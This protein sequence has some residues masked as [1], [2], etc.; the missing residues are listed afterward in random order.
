MNIRAS[1][2]TLLVTAELLPEPVPADLVNNAVRALQRADNALGNL[3]AYVDARRDLVCRQASSSRRPDS[4]TRK[5]E[6]STTSDTGY[7]TTPTNKPSPSHTRSRDEPED[8]PP[9]RTT[10]G[11]RIGNRAR[12]D[13][14]RPNTTAGKILIF[15]LGNEDSGEDSDGSD[16]I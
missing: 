15:N 16:W 7:G 4:P 3:Q 10:S 1:L 8:P 13:T 9:P 12:R 5:R 2:C 11:R 14:P 6:S